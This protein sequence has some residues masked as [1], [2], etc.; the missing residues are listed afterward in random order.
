MAKKDGSNALEISSMLSPEIAEAT[1]RLIPYGGEMKP[2][3]RFTVI[4]SPKCI[5]SIP[6]AFTTG[7][8]IGA[9]SYT[10][11]DVYKRQPW[12]KAGTCSRVC[13]RF[14]LMASLRSIA[15]APWASS[16][17]AVTGLSS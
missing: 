13:T 17:L 14:G 1:K 6:I 7:S 2:Q 15:I 5:G 8:R 12:M 4:I 3:A 16:S 10:H 9:V 11:L